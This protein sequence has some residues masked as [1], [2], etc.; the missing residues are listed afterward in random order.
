[1]KQTLN[2]EKQE[3][4]FVRLPQREY[5]MFKLP[6]G[7]FKLYAWLLSHDNGYAFSNYYMQQGTKMKYKAIKNALDYLENKKIIT[8][9]KSSSDYRIITIK[10]TTLLDSSKKDSSVLLDS[11]LL[12]SSVLLDS[13]L[14]DSSVLLDSSQKDSTLL[15][16]SSVLLDSSSVLL[17]TKVVSK[18]TTKKN[19]EDKREDK[20]EDKTEVLNIEEKFPESKLTGLTHKD[21]AGVTDIQ[22][23]INETQNLI[24]IFV[25]GDA[26]DKLI[27]NYLRFKVSNPRITFPKYESLYVVCVYLSK[28]GDNFEIKNTDQLS[29]AIIKID[30][31]QINEKINDMS[32]NIVSKENYKTAAIKIINKLKLK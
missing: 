1:M 31:I 7:A 6:L 27:T 25:K 17:D 30:T 12:D 9:Q 22:L 11:T 21:V 18:V 16:S 32:S 14:L 4:N 15:D 3:G 20:T 2:K 26:Q 19:K 8:I 23:P 24:S 29:E 28:L 13:T 10:T 5:G